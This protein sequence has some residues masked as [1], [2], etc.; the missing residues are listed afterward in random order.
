VLA[1]RGIEQQR[2]AD[3]VP[4][5]GLALDQQL[6]DRLGTGRASGLAGKPGGDAGALKCGDEELRLGRFA[7]PLPAF[8][9]DEISAGGQWRLPQIR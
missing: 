8:E 6:T 3:R 4:A 2:L 1:P 5:F 7:G 9:R